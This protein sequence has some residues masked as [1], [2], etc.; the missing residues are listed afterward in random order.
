MKEFER[1][2]PSNWRAFSRVAGCAIAIGGGDLSRA[3]I[4][5]DSTAMTDKGTWDT[6]FQTYIGGTLFFGHDVDVQ[7]ADDFELATTYEI[8]RVTA[9]YQ[10]SL[11]LPPASGVLVEFFDDL[12]G[13]PSESPVA[14][15]LSTAFT[16]TSIDIGIGEPAF[17]IMVDL[18][19]D[20]ITLGSG[21]WWVS[22]TP[23]DDTEE[24]DKYNQLASTAGVFGNNTHVRDGGSDHGN[25]LPGLWGID[26][27]TLAGDICG[28][29]PYAD[30][31]MK[32]EGTPV[33]PNCPQDLD[34]DG[35]VGVKD[36]LNLLGVWGPCPAKGDCPADFDNSDDVSV[37]DL[38]E[39]L[40][41]WGPCP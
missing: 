35:S 34:G 41:A 8:T 26:D 11:G 14:G 24:G 17:R 19:G 39:L 37:K 31:A 25:G 15:V 21:R 20:D 40:G 22:I 33:K 10:A 27:W 2:V 5:Y 1:F 18:A 28:P 6:T 36:L 7:A 38:L 23:F 4:L 30:L 3:D 29:C 9:D 16:A 32:I 12:G 13:M